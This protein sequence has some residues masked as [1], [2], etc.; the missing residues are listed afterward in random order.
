[1]AAPVFQSRR[2]R[3]SERPVWPRRD[4]VKEIE[5]TEQVRLDWTSPRSGAEDLWQRIQQD[6]QLLLN[7]VSFACENILLGYSFQSYDSAG[8]RLDQALQQ[9][10]A[11]WEVVQVPGKSKFQ[12]RRRVA[13]ATT[14]A[15]ARITGMGGNASDHL[16]RAW[17]HAYGRDPDPSRAYAEAVKAVEA[18]TIP[19]VA[20]NDCPRSGRSSA[21]CA[22]SPPSGTRSWSGRCAY[23]VADSRLPTPT[24]SRSSSGNWTCS[25]RTRPIATL[26]ATRSCLCRSLRLRRRQL[27][28]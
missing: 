9:A 19:V 12:L 4:F 27:C 13:V 28:T 8:R 2:A 18:A 7:V 3:S 6:P 21:T 17:Q 26:Q 11:N 1:M 23:R 24:L 25:G 22:L 14:E 20:P 10:G 16:D 5:R 15:V